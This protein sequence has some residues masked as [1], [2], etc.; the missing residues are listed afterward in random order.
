VTEQAVRERRASRVRARAG[1]VDVRV[2]ASRRPHA[3]LED[4]EDGDGV[5]GGDEGAKG[6]A[7][8]HAHRV[9]QPHLAGR[10]HQ[11]AH[12]KRGEEGAD[13]SKE[14]RRPEVCHKGLDVHVVAGLEDDGREEPGHEELEVELLVRADH[15]VA[16]EDGAVRH[17]GADEDSDAR[18]RQPGDLIDLED[19]AADEGG[20]KGE[21]ADDVAPFDFGFLDRLGL[22]LRLLF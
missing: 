21:D 16:S 8:E 10:E 7:G 15:L 14:H 4:G 12:H 3:D 19:V 2:C 18:L 5:G 11:P 20:A 1:G 6:E 13:E 17:A 22:E 9:A